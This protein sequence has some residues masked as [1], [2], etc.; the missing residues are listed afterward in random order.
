MAGKEWR[1]GYMEEHL[2]EKKL[3]LIKKENLF[4]LSFW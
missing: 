3:I 4:R 1:G 2:N